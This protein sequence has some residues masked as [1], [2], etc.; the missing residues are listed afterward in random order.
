MKILAEILDEGLEGAFW[1][2]IFCPC[3]GDSSFCIRRGM[4]V[5][6]GELSQ[7]ITLKGGHQKLRRLVKRGSCIYTFLEGACKTIWL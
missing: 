7:K 5:I 1:G 6:G 2:H 4:V 3:V